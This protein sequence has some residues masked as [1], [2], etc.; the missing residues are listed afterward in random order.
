MTLLHVYFNLRNQQAFQRLLERDRSAASA[1]STSA[2]K[3]SWSRG[4]LAS[5]VEVNAFDHLGRTVLHLACSSTEPASL[6]YARM[7]L[8]HPAINANIVDKENHWTALHRAAYVGNI[9][10]AILLLKR[11]DVDTLIKDME[12][13]TAFDL[14]NSTVRSA[15]PSSLEEGY[16]ELFTWGA[17]RNAA[18]GLGDGNDRAH[19]DQVVL[20]KKE[21]PLPTNRTLEERFGPV[22]VREVSMS[23]LHTVILTDEP[24]D[25]LRLCGFGS[26]GRLGPSPHTLYTPTPLALSSYTITSVALGQDH[27]IAL[28][29]AGEVLTWGLNRFSQLGYIVEAGQGGSVDESVQTTPRKIGHLRKEFVKGVAA[30]KSASACWSEIDVWTWGV[31]GGQL[32]YSKT[33]SPV[34]VLPRKVSVI[35]QP[36]RGISMSET[37]MVCLFV[38]GDV[39]CVW[40]GGVSKIN[41]P[42]HAFPSDISIVYRPPQAVRGPAIT[43]VASCDDTFAALSSNGEVFT[44]SAPAPTEGEGGAAGSRG[45]V[46]KPQRAWALRRQFSSV[47]DVDIGSDGTLIV[48]TQS[49][50]VF[51]RS[52]N[53][54]G[55]TTSGGTKAFKF[56]RVA[57]IQRAVAVCAN[58]TGAFGALRVE[59]KPPP[60]HIAGRLFS[61]DMVAIAPY[62]QNGGMAEQLAITGLDSIIAG[63]DDVE[64]SSILDDIAEMAKLMDVLHSQHQREKGDE[65]TPLTHVLHGAD[66]TVR[67]G[68]DFQI[69]AHRLVFA[70]RCAPLQ[71][72]LKG[73]AELRDKASK[74]SVTFSSASD[75]S[76][77]SPHP[78]L[79]HFKGVNPLT[80][81]IFLHYLYSDGILAIWDRRIGSLFE[82][83]FVSLGVL[84]SQV[85]TE[86][87]ALARL[88]ELPQLT[89]ALQSLAKR[90]PKPSACVDFRRLF[91]Q[92]QLL[93]PR[94]NAHTD[95]LAPDVALH[96]ADKIVYTHSVVLRA[97]CPFFAAFFGDQDWTSKRK[98]GS[99][100]VDVQMKHREWRVMQFV[101]Q[102]IC[103]G[104]EKLFETLEFLSTVDEV[105]EFMFLIISAANELLLNRLTL[106]CSEV[107]L[108]HLNANNACYLL[109]DAI[110]FNAV[111]LAKSIQS[112]MAANLEMLLESRILDELDP[113][114]ARKLAEHTRSEQAEKSPVSRSD[115]LA[116]EAIEKHKDWLALQDI[117]GP[118]VPNPKALHAHRDSPKMSPP[119]SARKSGRPLKLSSPAGSP[120]L[121]PTSAPRPMLHPGP[122]GDELFAMDAEVIP[123]LELHATQPPPL[124]V[125]S[126][127]MLVWKKNPSTPRTDLKS[128]M[129]EAETSNKQT[130]QGTSKTPDS[131]TPSRPSG[132]R[133]KA[134]N[135]P[136][137]RRI[138]SDLAMHKISPQPPRPTGSPA[139]AS[140]N[141]L[142]SVSS[143]AT[144]SRAGPSQ[145]NMGPMITPVR[146][147]PS[148]SGSST[149]RKASSGAAWTLPPAQPVV[150]PSAPG[151]SLSFA[152]IQQLQRMQDA[153][154]PKDKRSLREIQE[155]EQARQEARQQEDDFLKWWAAEEERVRLET[156][157]QEQLLLQGSNPRPSSKSRGGN[158]SN[159]RKP[160][161]GGKADQPSGSSAQQREPQGNRKPRRREDANK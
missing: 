126:K 5:A 2:G 145:L 74:I 40:S 116:R 101:L 78:E 11:A 111:D 7:L 113:R 28:T 49:G 65:T 152:E 140:P 39:A 36:V 112:Y 82:G 56:Q 79:L 115:K 41:F 19:P 69:Y 29:T 16:A 147:M 64:D 26:G 73:D 109:T 87:V 43:K 131:L 139:K 3:S 48:C 104:E 76:P 44:F 146:Q 105:L 20:P 123:T 59:Y 130:V 50:H 84:P 143:P 149:P 153:P 55:S 137:P 129:A 125:S 94:R 127:P 108:K 71:P 4:N 151:T 96:L 27:T 106:L 132:S 118:F 103:F 23:K 142:P 8:A 35:T 120:L 33:A 114:V 91:D 14:Y 144:V 148:A 22:K 81:L 52:R 24:R 97:R 128:I 136:A 10:A 133:W 32:G 67:V 70:T 38:S 47:R 1:P 160:K 17:N 80:L 12:G 134:D 141:P 42:A 156:Q 88:L 6:E 122:S 37:A 60:I 15:N 93:A 86:L 121:R 150:Q 110:H 72:V 90:V 68:R 61:A 45:Q 54:K 77:S 89:L 53:L 31:N 138:P 95:P 25:N 9:E 98:D 100:V 102:F 158:K 83:H 13:Y 46:M 154:A 18:L 119:G 63:D 107:I 92:A 21:A 161:A 159:P 85:K 155:E 34:Q 117:P 62:I 58:S 57:H 75:S 30:C 66:L 124:D 51:V 135:P 99:G 157:Q